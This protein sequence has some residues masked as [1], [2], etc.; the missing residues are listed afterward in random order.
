M[1]TAMPKEKLQEVFDRITRE[2]TAESVGIEL[3]QGETPPGEDLCTVHITFKKG[4]HSGLSLSAD[5]AMLTRLTQ[6][7]LQEEE[8][9]DQDVE[10]VTK[11]YFNI[12]C[13]RIAGA[14]FQA[15]K[16]ASRFSVPDFHTG[17]FQPEDYQEQFVLSYSGDQPGAVQL[18]HHIPASRGEGEE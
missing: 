13:G 3:K 6:S 18:R 9:T 14:L 17:Q 5:S 12:L 2:V 10:D 1:D 7:F 8:I 15:T 4:F 11:E 16:I